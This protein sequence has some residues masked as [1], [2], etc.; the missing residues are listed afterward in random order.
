MKLTLLF[1]AYNFDYDEWENDPR[2]NILYLGE[3]KN[4]NTRNTLVG[5]INLNYLTKQQIRKLRNFI[6]NR[7]RDIGP[8]PEKELFGTTLRE[9]ARTIRGLFPDVFDRAYRTYDKSEI[10]KLV[11]GPFGEYMPGEYAGELLS[12]KPEIE[13][14]DRHD[15]P[16]DDVDIDPRVMTF[17]VPTDREEPEEPDEPEEPQGTPS[18]PTE[19]QEEPIDTSETPEPEE[20]QER[21]QRIS[22]PSVDYD[23]P[24]SSRM[25]SIR[26]EKL[27]KTS[28]LSGMTIDPDEIDTSDLPERIGSINIRK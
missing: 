16:E 15:K 1:E 19:P 28:G 22:A 27:D 25:P 14:D 18:L 8:V 9:A 7:H 3:Y 2:P 21:G 26:P 4:K 13:P 5:G 20:R 17:S 11:S 12:D 10:G 6:I 24:V 23:A